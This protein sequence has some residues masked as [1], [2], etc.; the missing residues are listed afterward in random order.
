MAFSAPT[1][2]P[3]PV[4]GAGRGAGVPVYVDGP[5][6]LH[7]ADLRDAAGPDGPAAVQLEPVV[8]GELLDGLEAAEPSAAVASRV[9][10]ALTT[11]AERL[12]GTGWRINAEVPGPALRSRWR[13]PPAVTAAAD[14]RLDRGELCARGYDRV[15]RIA[16]SVSDLAAQTRPTAS[17]VEKAVALRSRWSTRRGWPGLAR[18]AELGGRVRLPTV[19]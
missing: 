2:Q 13:L 15:L 11:A 19:V 6:A 1:G 16:W 3:V 12:R 10:A 8:P 7:R 9:A 14:V 5:A 17:D 18:A 4:R